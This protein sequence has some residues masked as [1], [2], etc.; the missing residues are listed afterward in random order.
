MPLLLPTIPSLYTPQN[1]TP[2]TLKKTS[3]YG[4]GLNA[5]D[6]GFVIP[7]LLAFPADDE[8]AYS[9]AVSEYDVRDIERGLISDGMIRIHEH[10][11]DPAK[12]HIM[13][14]FWTEGIP[15]DISLVNPEDHLFL[16]LD[17]DPN[18]SLQGIWS[19]HAGGTGTV[20]NRHGNHHITTATLDAAVKDMGYA[21]SAGFWGIPATGAQY[22]PK[23]SI[24]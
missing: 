10:S 18:G 19:Y 20:S 21:H 13:A 23:I 6:A 14:A 5:V 8:A 4:Y 15:A 24:S 22:E 16:K 1:W 9:V 2:D 12:H 7:G 17:C 11:L 3:C